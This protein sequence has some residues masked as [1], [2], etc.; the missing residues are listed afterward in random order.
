MHKPQRS[1][2]NKQPKLKIKLLFKSKILLLIMLLVSTYAVGSLGK[3]TIQ[4]IQES[5][6]ESKG[7]YFNSNVITDNRTYTL[8]NWDGKTNYSFVA[9]ILNYKNDEVWTKEDIKY[10]VTINSSNSGAICELVG[11]TT[12]RILTGSETEKN[13]DT[14]TFTLKNNGGNFKKGDS[15]D[16]KI[17]ATA[18][19]PY[20]KK[21]EATFKI[22]V[23]SLDFNYYVT[24]SVGSNYCTLYISSNIADKT[25]NIDVNYA[26]VLFDNTNAFV[27][28]GQ[29]LTEEADGTTYIKTLKNMLI[30]KD[31]IYA[32]RFYKNDSSKNYQQDTTAINIHLAT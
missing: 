7:F 19:E 25:V 9:D 23:T 5:Y 11:E 22:Y 6:L 31:N 27:Q 14:L 20:N 3:F 8:N 2:K 15:V 4:T 28:E 17:V 32:I 18:K 24:D 16:I 26:K 29:T 10:D 13:K 21:I 30:K 1:K 12:N